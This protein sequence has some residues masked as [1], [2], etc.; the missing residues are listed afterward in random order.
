MA[1]KGKKKIEQPAWHANF[2][3]AEG[4]PDI[5]P[6]RTDFLFNFVALA[7]LLALGGYVAYTEYQALQLRSS[8]AVL[9]SRIQAGTLENNQNLRLSAEFDRLSV[10]MKEAGEFV[11][12]PVRPTDLLAE[13]VDSLPAEML[14]TSFGLAD[15]AIQEG[16]R[17]RY[18]KTLTL[19]GNV[20]SPDSVRS[21]Q[22]VN[23]YV[24][25]VGTLP[26]LGKEVE[27]TSLQS[28]QRDEKQGIFTFN[29]MVELKAR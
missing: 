27:K 3:N 9:N 15:R 16:R 25:V 7:A 26:G 23:D 22:I 6:I 21:T 29:I 5:K 13:V 18:A 11:A 1:R 8:I 17:T 28:L 2:R 4:L 19:A 12:M 14:V 20:S 24:A 10:L